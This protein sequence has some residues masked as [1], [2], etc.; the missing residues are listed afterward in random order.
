MNVDVEKVMIL[1]RGKDQTQEIISFECNPKNR[2]VRI[3]YKS[4]NSYSFNQ[5][6]VT[7]I[8]NPKVIE[9]N[10]CVAFVD[11]IPVYE[12]RRILDFGKWIRIVKYNGGAF[13]VSHQSFSVVKNGIT[14]Q[15]AQG[16]L[17]YLK[18]IAQYTSGNQ[19]EEKVWQ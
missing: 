7:I 1:I 11:D 9:L 6:N 18:D 8:N 14:S 16:I 2:K 12:P 10:E 15:S 13:T 3:T 19:E 5:D 4:G 17:K